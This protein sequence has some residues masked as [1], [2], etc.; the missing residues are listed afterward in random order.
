VEGI[1]FLFDNVFDK[2]GETA[3]SRRHRARFAPTTRP[4]CGE[5]ASNRRCTLIID[6]NLSKSRSAARADVPDV[7]LATTSA[8][9]FERGNW[10]RRL[11]SPYRLCSMVGSGW[12]HAARRVVF[13][14]AAPSAQIAGPCWQRHPDGA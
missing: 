13:R 8:F 7:G 9:E 12:D 11:I 1:D 6:S 2:I 14:N 4:N 5:Y 10:P 3:L